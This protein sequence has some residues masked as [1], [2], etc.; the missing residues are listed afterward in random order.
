MVLHSNLGPI[1]PSFRDIR[2]RKL[3]ATLF[4]T[5]RPH[6]YSV[7]ISVFPLDRSAMLESA[8]RRKSRLISHEIIFEVI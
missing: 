1:L 3:K 8:E 4:H 7:K 6:P 2:A 5:P